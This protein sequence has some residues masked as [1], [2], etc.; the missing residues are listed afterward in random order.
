MNPF[1]T[2]ITA[3]SAQIRLSE[4]ESYELNKQSKLNEQQSQ[5]LIY[6]LISEVSEVNTR[7]EMLKLQLTSSNAL[8]EKEI[9]QLKKE[10]QKEVDSLLNGVKLKIALVS[11]KVQAIVEELNI[12]LISDF[13]KAN[14][15]SEKD[16]ALF[17]KLSA[18]ISKCY[19]KVIHDYPTSPDLKEKSLEN[20]QKQIITFPVSKD[21]QIT[22]SDLVLQRFI[23][24]ARERYETL[25]LDVI[26][27]DEKNND[28]IHEKEML[29]HFHQKYLEKFKK[30]ELN[31]QLKE[32]YDLISALYNQIEWDKLF[33]LMPTT[34]PSSQFCN[35]ERRA[36][37]IK[38][39]QDRLDKK[40]NK[41]KEQT[42]LIMTD[43]EA[44][45]N[46]E[47]L[48]KEF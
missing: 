14:A 13:G 44:I 9:I 7:L 25:K 27:L 47:N 2:S 43:L 4:M 30:E 33:T 26:P 40:A 5:L 6:Q 45:V 16:V 24:T 19:E 31:L 22:Q 48:K 38:I 8:L 3:L 28:L 23:E 36:L 42:K 11:T 34:Y 21:L 12:C 35:P 29:V 32:I 17:K 41:I 46:A 37:F 10:H 1:S 39:H 20:N 18:D 15:T